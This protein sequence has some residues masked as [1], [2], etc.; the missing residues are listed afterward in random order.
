MIHRKRLTLIFI[1]VLI[2]STIILGLIGGIESKVSNNSNQNNYINRSSGYE[3]NEILL[4]ES[5]WE[6]YGYGYSTVRFSN[7]ILHLVYVWMYPDVAP[8]YKIYYRKSYD[9]GMTWGKVTLLWSGDWDCEDLDMVVIGSD[10]HLIWN[11]HNGL[12]Y[13]RSIDNGTTWGGYK[14][15]N[16]FWYC[17]DSSLECFGNNL[18][19]IYY[20]SS[21]SK[22]LFF[23]KS[24]DN[25]I[26][27]DNGIKLVDGSSPEIPAYPDIAVHED[28]IHVVWHDNRDGNFEIYYKQSIDGGISWG[29]DTRLTFTLNQSLYPDID[30]HGSNIHIVWYENENRTSNGD[31][32]IY[33][34]RSNNNGNSWS[35]VISL[36]NQIYS[37]NSPD[38]EVIDKNIHFVWTEYRNGSGDLYYKKSYDNGDN[39][40]KEIKISN[41]GNGIYRKSFTIYKTRSFF[42]WDNV[43]GV[44]FKSIPFLPM[45]GVFPSNEST[46]VTGSTNIIMT[47]NQPMNTNSV[48]NAFLI[49]PNIQGSFYWDYEKNKCV[50]IPSSN[51]SYNTI[52]SIKLDGTASNLTSATLDG[53]G[54]GISEGTPIDDF[55]WSFTIEKYINPDKNPPNIISKKPIDGAQNVLVNTS[56]RVIFNE[57]MNKSSTEAAYSIIPK[58]D[59][60]FNW[61]GNDKILTFKP[62]SNLN[63]S[64]TYEIII[65]GVAKD[66]TGN[67]LDGNKNGNAEGSPIDD[68]SWN[69]T[70]AGYTNFKPIVKIDSP[71]NNSVN[72]I[73]GT[74]Y[75]DCINTTDPDGD[76]LEFLWASNISGILSKNSQF[77]TSLPLGH[78]QITLYVNDGYGHNVSVSVKIIVIPWNCLPVAIIDHP[79]NNDVFNDTDTIRFEASSSYDLDL[80]ALEFYWHSNIT[81]GFGYSS[82]FS[83]K[84][85]EGRH[86]ITLFVNDGH[87][88]NVSISINI[89]V[90]NQ[91]TDPTNGP[92]DN[93][94]PGP[95]STGQDKG[96]LSRYGLYIGVILIIVII[97]IFGFAAATEVGKYGLLSSFVPL[98]RRLKGKKVL[99]NETRGMVRGYILANP[100]EHYSIIKRT[101][102]LPNGT[103]TYHLKVLEQEELV[104]SE[105]D[106]IY[107]RFY[108]VEMQLP[109]NATHL[110]KIQE[111]IL[112]EI[113]IK[114]GIT[115]GELGKKI[116]INP[117]V[118]NYHVKALVSA[119]LIKAERFGKRNRYYV[120]E[121][122]E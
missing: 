69:F 100:G 70:T 39:W 33:Y 82:K 20:L 96:V 89:V 45:V 106:G 3:N 40:S 41:F 112:N 64:T 24:E 99:D 68:Y 110:T 116:K 97:T 23:N 84:L 85:P 83:A 12:N 67:T 14:N 32:E 59:G 51:L 11:D 36:T 104:K 114:P 121:G 25:G 37:D 55:K 86:F 73:N 109:K 119:G 111:T 22:D 93:G 105:R 66:L 74:T 87:Y 27:W 63:Y 103:L 1:F 120:I 107:K 60:N 17:D 5:A 8:M 94:G 34:L 92:T 81:G 75:F 118:I 54:N 58:V 88:H 18:Y 30:V 31:E 78:H 113:I 90:L 102:K 29:N 79:K 26:T 19:V 61:T 101:L 4:E 35:K 42:A 2:Q 91:T 13:L 62:N 6:N 77:Y 9:Y 108:P 43:Y 65:L 56:I 28:N 72:Y 98:Y 38:I 44:Y 16:E 52:Y 122:I 10:L 49:F 48:E 47:F 21:N 117:R 46:N 76:I 80:D 57:S 115:V 50:F 15:L 7:N 95:P 71:L 53:N